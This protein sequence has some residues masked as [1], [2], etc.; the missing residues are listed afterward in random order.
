MDGHLG[1]LRSDE[2]EG[3]EIPKMPVQTIVITGAGNGIGAATARL[4][5]M[6]DVNLVLADIDEGS[7]K[8][9]VSACGVG[10]GNG[11]GCTIRSEAAPEC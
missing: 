2:S 7:L 4:L 6:P 9:I 8:K 1:Q 5:A 3:A 10:R 11:V